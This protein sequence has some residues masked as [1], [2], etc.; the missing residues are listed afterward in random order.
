ML[1][2]DDWTYTHQR[3]A[4]LQGWQLVDTDSLGAASVEIRCI[5]SHAKSNAWA[6]RSNH[7][8]NDEVAVKAMKEAFL[9][10][11]DHAVLAYHIIKNTS[12]PEF[13]MWGMASWNHQR[14]AA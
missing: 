3:L 2:Y 10:D 13:N 7:A 8:M 4:S 12:V 14:Q 1:N 6:E 11:E 9:R 5:D